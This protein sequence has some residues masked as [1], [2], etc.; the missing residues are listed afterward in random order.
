[1]SHRFLSCVLSFAVQVA[2][3]SVPVARFARESFLTAL[4][5][6]TT[7]LDAGD[8]AAA[9]AG[10][11]AALAIRI[12]SAVCAEGLARVAAREGDVERAFRELARAE[13][14]GLDDAS[15]VAG[16]PDFAPLAKDARMER[17][18][19]ELR[20][21]R[22]LVE[23]AARIVKLQLEERPPEAFLAR[24]LGSAPDRAG[25]W[26]VAPAA[27]G[28]IVWAG[29]SDG[30]VRRI[31][32]AG[33]RVLESRAVSKN[34]LR[35][36]VVDRAETNLVVVDIN[37]RGWL[38]D[39]GTLATRAQFTLPDH[40]RFTSVEVRLN[41][42]GDRLLAAGFGGRVELWRVPE[43]Q[44]V[45]VLAAD[46]EWRGAVS[47]SR[48]GEWLAA[49]GRDGRV[50][51]F[52]SADGVE[53]GRPFDLG[54]EVMALAIDST[55]R[56]L[57]AAGAGGL[58]STWDVETSERLFESQGDEWGLG[59]LECRL[60]F[61][62]KEPRL[63]SA[64][65]GWPPTLRLW[66][67]PSGKLEW[68]RS[69]ME[70]G[71]FHVPPRFDPAGRLIGCISEPLGDCAF[72]D[73][74]A[75]VDGP[76]WS[77]FLPNTIDWTGDGARIIVSG[78][79]SYGTADART[80][81]PL[82]QRFECGGAGVWIAGSLHADGDELAWRNAMVRVGDDLHTLEGYAAMLASA[83]RVR[84]NAAGRPVLEARLAPPPTL[85]L[86]GPEEAFV[87]TQATRLA[88]EFLARSGAELLGFEVEDVGARTTTTYALERPQGASFRWRPVFEFGER[89]VVTLRVRAIG[90][91]G[92]L[93][94]SVVLRIERDDRKTRR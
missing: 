24:W 90:S 81:S 51:R 52:R 7:A 32:V 22:G 45:R 65:G 84:A 11:E 41:R 16:D 12:E 26:L 67:V 66:S 83:A 3:P 79:F 44:S 74:L 57:A 14:W 28:S 9:R 38:L 46:P 18:L 35:H 62:P 33:P 21:R 19:V 85:A 40:A 31:D 29:S 49:G 78:A 39:P 36:L 58:L 6:G 43:M 8:L 77:R 50:R 30:R 56:W 17:F 47:W 13:R 94:D 37:D 55:G 23:G 4:A 91:G 63:F 2:E 73:A 64:I 75:G 88:Y 48:D 54:H 1:M 60:R 34:Y 27:S 86:V 5:R 71:Y 72:F 89:P 76:Y 25:S 93:S 10:F 87:R 82:V 59:P 68:E 53:F 20:G 80:G 42:S 15:F 92:I 70:D 69:A 61:A